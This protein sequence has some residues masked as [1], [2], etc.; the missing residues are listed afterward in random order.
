M[1]IMRFQSN[2]TQ[3]EAAS[4]AL[5]GFLFYSSFMANLLETREEAVYRRR[6]QQVVRANLLGPVVT[7]HRQIRRLNTN[8]TAKCFGGAARP[9]L[10][11]RSADDMLKQAHE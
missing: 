8:L 5:L 10:R 1:P 6:L 11:Q 3:A 4:K 7:G 9:L 2:F